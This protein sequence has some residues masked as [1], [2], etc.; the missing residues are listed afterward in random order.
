MVKTAKNGT[1]CLFGIDDRDEGEHCIMEDGKYGSFGWCWTSQKK[2][3]WGSCSEDCP[4]FGVFKI[5][6]KKIE[7]L[8]GQ[9]SIAKEALANATGNATAQQGTLDDQDGQVE[10]KIVAAEED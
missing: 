3:T 2:D 4:L 10:D 9:L 8:R 7:K 5:L 6:G 1:S